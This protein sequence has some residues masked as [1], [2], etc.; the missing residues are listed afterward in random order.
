MD[1]NGIWILILGILAL[2]GGAIITRW[3]SP[4]GKKAL[5]MLAGLLG[6][7]IAIVIL[8]IIA[9]L[10]DYF[11]PAIKGVDA[12]GGAI[13]SFFLVSAASGAVGLLVNWLVSSTR[14]RNRVEEALAE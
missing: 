11:Q 13:V 10:P 5:G 6:G 14:T 9:G 8:E 7:I 2:P 4:I 12:L 1:I 3:M